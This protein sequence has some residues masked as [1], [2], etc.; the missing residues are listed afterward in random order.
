MQLKLHRGFFLFGVA[1]KKNLLRFSR[2]H[3]LQG[4]AVFRYN[5]VK[6]LNTWISDQSTHDMIREY[7]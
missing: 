4:R 6:R 5:Q 3:A 2:Q 1:R 7:F